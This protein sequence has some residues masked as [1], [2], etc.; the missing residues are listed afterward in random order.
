MKGKTM[1]GLLAVGT[2]VYALSKMQNQGISGYH[3]KRMKT[4]YGHHPMKGAHAG[5]HAGYHM[6]GAHMKG[7]HAGYHAGYHMK[8]AHMKGAHAGYHAPSGYHHGYH[9][10]AGYHMGQIDGFAGVY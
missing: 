8:G 10:N 7:A 5:Y 2:A 9:A 3:N 1:I 4:M 6:K